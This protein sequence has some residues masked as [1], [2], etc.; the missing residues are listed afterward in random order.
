M[1]GMHVYILVY[2]ISCDNI[3]YILIFLVLAIMGVPSATDEFDDM[4]IVFLCLEGRR[5]LF[6]CYFHVNRPIDPI[7][8]KEHQNN[9]ASNV[10]L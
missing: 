7:P 8:S 6:Q 3:I 1:Y 2:I 5:S 10:K 9:T 4:H